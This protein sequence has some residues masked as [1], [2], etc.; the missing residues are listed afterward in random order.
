MKRII[1]NRKNL[2]IVILVGGKSYRSGSEK[3]GL[4]FR[5]KPLLLHQIETLEK[6][7]TDL[8]L[9]ANSEEQ[10][11]FFKTNL[12]IPDQTKIIVDNREIFP[13]TGIFTPMLGVYSSLKELDNLNYNKALILSGDAPLIKKSVIELLISESNDFDCTIP[14]WN[15]EFL[16]PLFA[17]YPVKKGYQRAK[18]C[19]I[20][21]TFSLNRLVDEN[22]K[23][24]YLSVEDSIQPL[25]NNLVSL[26]NVNGPIDIEKLMSFIDE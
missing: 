12:S 8:F 16:E 18:E 15:N 17:I 20:N 21:K 24:N 22:W 3:V 9:T 13:Y 6:I 26:I 19:I 14:R 10:A 4:F 1:I 11:N 23:I 2:A 7:K 5:R 25:D